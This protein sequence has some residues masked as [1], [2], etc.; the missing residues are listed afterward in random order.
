MIRRYLLA[1]DEINKMTAI[2]YESARDKDILSRLEQIIDDFLSFLI[3]AYRYG[4]ENAGL[5][6]AYDTEVDVDTMRDVIYAI[7]DGKTFEDRIYNHLIA[8]DLNGLQTL[9]ESEYH[10]VY[11][12]AVDDGARQYIE[13]TDSGVIKTW[14]TVGDALVRDT[15]NYLEG[16]S[17]DYYEDFYTFDGDHAAVPGGFEKAENNVNCR[18]WI[19]L[20]ASDEL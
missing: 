19:T 12:Q 13:Q 16:T 7:I 3:N 20:K 8:D 4:I 18:C 15:H 17:V 14:H 2:S 9:A 10:R 1:F 11:N 5:M 6:L